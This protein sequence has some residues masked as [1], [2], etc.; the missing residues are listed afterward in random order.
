MT[1]T[2]AGAAS[3]LR[4]SQRIHVCLRSCAKVSVDFNWRANPTGT[5]WQFASTI[6]MARINL[7]YDLAKAAKASDGKKKCFHF[8]GVSPVGD[9]TIT[10]RVTRMA[11]IGRRPRI[12]YR[13][14]IPVVQPHRAPRNNWRLVAS[15]PAQGFY[16][17]HSCTVHESDCL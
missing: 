9:G 16:R 7:C 1:E 13:A 12:T 11:L 15:H 10:S 3:V 4:E 17:R 8:S 14:T 5:T 2:F 6:L